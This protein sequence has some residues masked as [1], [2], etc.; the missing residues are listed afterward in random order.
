[1]GGYVKGNTNDLG[2]YMDEYMEKV[3]PRLLQGALVLLV[4]VVAQTTYIGSQHWQPTC[5]IIRMGE[6]LLLLCN[7]GC[8][9]ICG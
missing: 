2:H 4:H 5:I 6:A 8:D 9:G 3:L 1:M 7:E